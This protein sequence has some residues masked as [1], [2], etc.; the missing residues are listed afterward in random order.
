MKR[1]VKYALSAVLVSAMVAPAFAQDNFPDAPENHW[2]YEA[3]GR[4]KKDGILVGY[5]DSKYRGARPAT[6]YELAVAINAAYTKLKDMTDDLTK[7]IS[8]LSSKLDGKANQSDLDDVKKGLDDLKAQVAALPNYSSDIADLKML[9][10][11]FEKELASIGVDVDEQ[12]K[13]LQDLDKRVGV[14]EGRKLPVDIHGDLNALVMGGYST[15]STFGITEDARPTGYGRGTYSGLPVGVNRDLT[16]FHETG[17]ELTSTNTTG[18]KWKVVGAAGNMLEANN[19]DSGI[20]PQPFATQNSTSVGVPFGEAG[21]ETLYFQTF[22]LMFNEKIA[23]LDFTADLGRVGYKVS[24]YIFQR[25]DTTPYFVNDRWDNGEYSIDGGLLGFAI[26]SAKFSVIAGRTSDQ[27]TSAG[28]PF[29]TLSAGSSGV[30][31]YNLGVS[32][33]PVGLAPDLLTIDQMLGGTLSVPILG[34]ST[35]DVSYL[36]LD[37][38]TEAN[39]AAVGVPVLAN[40]VDVYGGDLT[41]KGVIPAGIGLTGGYSRSDVMENGTRIVTSHNQRATGDLSWMG[42]NLSLKAGYRY[43]EPNY[44]APGDWGRIGIWWN[45]TDIK[46]PTAELG[47]NFTKTLALKATGEYYNGT[48]L[49]GGFL[50]TSDKITRLTADLGYKFMPGA[51]VDLGIESVDWSLSTTAHTLTNGLKPYERWYTLGLGYDLSNNTMLKIMWQVSDYNSK[52]QPGFT[53]FGQPTARG[54]LITTQLSIKF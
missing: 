35:I 41:L 6:R 45:P 44:A 24:P 32:G 31:N 46:G 38:N 25:P 8:A 14:L 53:V 16:V 4:L 39:V 43:I 37:S 51:S 34:H 36:V 10:S 40:R 54:G 22:E 52:G 27:V 3:L 42:G 29:Q 2:A 50:S 47:Y 19:F 26:G 23:G 15:G 12:K 30:S 33:R 18:P 9:T 5:P 21:A 13:N 28:N 11:K 7:Q 48:G 20:N 1:T 17:L 49:S